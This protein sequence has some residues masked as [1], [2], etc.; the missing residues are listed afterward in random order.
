MLK[1]LLNRFPAL[2]FLVGGLLL[3]L[4]VESQPAPLKIAISKASPN[5]LNWLKRSDSAVKTINLYT[6]TTEEAL[7][8][9]STCSA[10]LVTGG[11]DVWPGWYG[12]ENDTARC[13]EQNR[14]RDSLEIALINKALVLK[15]PIMGICRGE[16]ILNVSLGGTL[17]IDLPTDYKSEILHQC[18]DY[19]SCVHEATPVAGS[20]LGKISGG[21]SALV[22]TNHHQAVENLAPLLICNATSADHLTEGIEWRDPTDK[23]FLLGVQWHPER[24]EVTNPLSGPIANEFIQQALIYSETHHQSQK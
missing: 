10:L 16:Q 13:T 1:N 24:M 4:Q 17:I 14:H 18:T 23:A 19:L 20:L 22:A 3:S 2:Y 21:K 5:Y 9:L 15:M 6:L 11:E 12:K 8:Q 7:Q